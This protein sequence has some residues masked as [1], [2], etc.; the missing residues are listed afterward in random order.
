MISKNISIIIP[1]TQSEYSV[2]EVIDKIN[3]QKKLSINNY[4][5]IAVLNSA[6]FSMLDIDCHC[7]HETQL[8]SPY[9]ARNKGIK[10]KKS[11]YYVFLDATCIPA[12]DWL[13]TL[14]KIIINEPDIVAANVKFSPRTASV[15][16]IGDIY[17]SIVNIDN[18]SSVKSRGVAKTA[19]LVVHSQVILEV[20]YF[21]EGIRSGGD[22][23]WTGLATS[24]GFNLEFNQDWIVR[25][26]SRNTKDLI[27][28]QFRVAK[29]WPNV[30]KNLSKINYSKMLVKKVLFG[31]VPP[32]PLF[33][34]RTSQRRS[35]SLTKINKVKLVV[36]GTVLRFVSSLGIIYGIIRKND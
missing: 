15:T 4:D 11:E 35:I 16:S 5:V 21:E 32:S 10:F 26:Y 6:E 9:N 18:E 3:I 23:I 36:F 25:K 1:Y 34:F 28:K 31:F 13:A 12:D 30:W 29:G 7:L 2:K 17:D 20:G 24:K 33:L 27:K 19:C 14:D 22:V 8:G